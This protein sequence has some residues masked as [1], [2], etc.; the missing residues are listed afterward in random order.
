MFLKIWMIEKQI[1][2][3]RKVNIKEIILITRNKYRGF[4]GRGQAWD[5]RSV[6]EVALLIVAWTAN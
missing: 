3:I 5:A 1:L 2:S 4:G 6:A